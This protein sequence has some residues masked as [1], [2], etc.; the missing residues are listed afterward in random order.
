MARAQPK[1]NDQAAR[2]WHSDAEPRVRRPAR[3]F[4]A[5]GRAFRAREGL[6]QCRLCAHDCRANRLAGELGLCGANDRTR[7]HLAQ[8]EM[9]E[10][11]ELIPTFAVALSGCDLRCAFCITGARSWNPGVGDAI[12]ASALARQATEALAA[13]ARTVTILGGEPTIHVPFLL[14]LVAALPDDAKLVLKTNGYGSAA[15]REWL[16]GL[17]DVW[18]VDDKFGGDGCAARLA[19]V[20]HYRAVVQENLVWAARETDLIVRHLLMPGHLECCWRPIAAWLGTHLPGVKVSL[21]TGFWPGWQGH[22][23]HE[24]NRPVSAC[25]AQRAQDI[26]IEW[27]LNLV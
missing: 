11:L 6:A 23:H 27:G 24:L 19:R 5:A 16:R 15:S 9:G 2:S 1:R 8:I 3:R 12:S 26:A 7:V 21:K 25:E 20:A 13:G 22:R 17:F 4:M 18:C 10:E 14:E